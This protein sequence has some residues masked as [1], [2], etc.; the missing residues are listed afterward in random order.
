MLKDGA[1]HRHRS[2]TTIT[3]R[4]LHVGLIYWDP[5]T[6]G[7]VQSQV[8]GR[9]EHL[10]YPD[11]P[12]RYTLFSKQ[13][14]PDPHPWPHVRTETF[15][16]WDRLSIAVSEYTASRDLAGKL[17]QV[18][19][20]DPFDLLDLHAG[21]TGPVIA[22]WSRRRCVPYVFTSHSA[23]FADGNHNFRWEVARYYAWSNRSAAAGAARINAVSGFLKQTWVR[24]GFPADAI[25]V[26]HTAISGHSS[27]DAR[28]AW[29]RTGAFNVL[30]VG[31]ET[32][33][34]GL[35]VLLEAIRLCTQ[36][37]A[38]DD[39]TSRSSFNR[40]PTGSASAVPTSG[41][42]PRAP[43][44]VAVKRVDAHVVGHADR[45]LLLTVVGEVAAESPLR[46]MVDRHGLPV[47]F[48]GQRPNGQVRDLLSEA[49]LVVIPSRYDACPVL[50]IEAMYAGAL[51]VATRVG[52]LAEQIEDG[53][54][55]MLVP[56]EDPQAIAHAITGIAGAPEEYQHLR[57][58]A[59]RRSEKFLWSARSAEILRQYHAVCRRTT[60][61]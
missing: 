11:G 52:G 21:G 48:L 22:R 50:A 4:P 16:G 7:G 25:D 31:R 41:E 57:A 43:R 38:V 46:E 20:Q 36:T 54:S 2:M 14:P 28:V 3:T 30:F 23:R 49:D 34:K 58:G 1:K 9:I 44:W 27:S 55:G 42:A 60:A 51:I 17:D 6:P 24:L 53:I 39:E 40:A 10:G 35:D 15:S 37:H 18:H 56:A 19:A 61:A 8:A 29:G 13:P 33:E 47:E 32:A 5:F 45:P 59:R 26:Q 12:V